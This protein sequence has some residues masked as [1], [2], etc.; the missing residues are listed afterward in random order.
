MPPILTS[1]Y[2][3]YDSRYNQFPMLVN[4]FP[5]CRPFSLIAQNMANIL[6]KR[7]FYH[8][9]IHDGYFPLS[10]IWMSVAVS[11]F[12]YDEQTHSELKPIERGKI[13]HVTCQFFAIFSL[14]KVLSKVTHIS[15][16]FIKMSSICVICQEPKA[17]EPSLFMQMNDTIHRKDPLIYVGLCFKYFNN[18]MTGCRMY[19]LTFSRL[20]LIQLSFVRFVSLICPP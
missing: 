10:T 6:G 13:F 16:F 20:I 17:P 3:D 11:L 19:L 12:C 2:P 15:L 18:C 8:K 1:A 14:K 9:S 7:Y 5:V 4:D